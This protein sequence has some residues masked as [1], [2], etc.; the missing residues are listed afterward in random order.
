MTKSYHLFCEQTHSFIQTSVLCKVLMKHRWLTGFHQTLH[1]NYQS[2][3]FFNRKI[4]LRI[5]SSLKKNKNIKNIHLAYYFS[6]PE[7][8][9]ICNIHLTYSTFQELK[10]TQFENYS[11]FLICAIYLF[12]K[13]TSYF[14][15]CWVLPLVIINPLKII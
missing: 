4:F 2:D 3:H 11:F 10:V 6:Q 14:L 5:T 7:P 9:S 13:N 8:V 1:I 15:D 12:F